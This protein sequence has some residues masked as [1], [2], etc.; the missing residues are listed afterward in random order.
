MR[1]GLIHF[2]DCLIQRFIKILKFNSLL[3]HT[4]VQIAIISSFISISQIVFS[5]INGYIEILMLQTNDYHTI[6]IL[7]LMEVSIVCYCYGFHRFMK[8]VEDKMAVR[9][10]GPMNFFLFATLCRITPI[11]LVLLFVSSIY[12]EAVNTCSEPSW[13]CDYQII[14][15]IL[16]ISS[17]IIPIAF[18]IYVKLHRLGNIW[19]PTNQ[20]LPEYFRRISNSENNDLSISNI[21]NY[22]ISYL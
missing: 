9:I 18:G 19:E 8:E 12:A 6:L 16:S 22:E 13:I 17:I 4:A 14:G 15:R 1:L 21:N 11:L 2:I 5:T 3:M 20:F 7:V 10:P